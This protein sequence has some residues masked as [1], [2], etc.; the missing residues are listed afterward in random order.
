MVQISFKNEMFQ[1]RTVVVLVERDIQR[2]LQ[3]L[4]EFVMDTII[5]WMDGRLFHPFVYMGVI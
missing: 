4:E 2:I 1:K 5:N 3:N